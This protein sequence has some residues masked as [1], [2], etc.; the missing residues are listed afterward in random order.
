MMDVDVLIISANVRALRWRLAARRKVMLIDAKR[1]RAATLD[2]PLGCNV[3]GE[4]RA[5]GRRRVDA[6]VSRAFYETPPDNFCG[7]PL[8]TAR[9]AVRRDARSGRR[10]NR[11]PA[12]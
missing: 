5:G 4:L 9:R 2:G 11:P 7:T 6:G 1:N 10:S 8:L 12:N 3:H